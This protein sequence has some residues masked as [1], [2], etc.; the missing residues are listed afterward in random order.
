TLP[1]RLDA[2][3]EELGRARLINPVFVDCTSDGQ[4]AA[5]YGRLFEAGLHVVAVN[6]KANSAPYEDYRRLPETSDRLKRRFFYETNVGAGLPVIGTLQ[7]LL[8][9]GDRVLR[10]EAILSGSLSFIFGLLE[11]GVPFSQAVRTAR[12]RGFTEP[13]PRDDLSGLDVARK[14]LILQREFGGDLEPEQVEVA[15]ALPASFDAGG[16]VETFLSRLPALDGAFTAQIQDLASR[17][18]ALRFVGTIDDAGCR[19][20]VRAV[21][22]DHPLHSIRGGENAF[23]FLT[24]HYQPRPLVVQGYGA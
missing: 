19:V 1:S 14:V 15:G 6:K 23:S 12:D 18:E 11:D 10:L 5:V 9:G 8:K 2:L 24:E 22:P 21:G 20:G 16:D 13:D 17:G 4:V 7:G 3:L